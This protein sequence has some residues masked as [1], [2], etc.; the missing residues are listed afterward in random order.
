MIMMQLHAEATYEFIP[1]DETNAVPLICK[2]RDNGQFLLA[3]PYPVLLDPTRR[4]ANFKK[5]QLLPR[6]IVEMYHMTLVRRHMRVKLENTSNKMNLSKAE[7]FL[8]SFECWKTEMGVIHPHPHI[9]SYFHEV[10]TLPNYFA[11]D[12]RASCYVCSKA[13]R[14]YKCSQ[15]RSTKYCSA[16]CQSHDWPRHKLSCHALKMPDK[17]TIE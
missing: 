1:F 6:Q 10:R 3:E 8:N 11:V 17:R 2:L 13:L 4:V 15:C 9:G 5:F 12:I 16:R 14:L 7:E